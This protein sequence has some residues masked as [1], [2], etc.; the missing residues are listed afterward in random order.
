MSRKKTFVGK[1]LKATNLVLDLTTHKVTLEGLDLQLSTYE[2]SLLKTFMQKPHQVLTRDQLLD[3]MRGLEWETEN[4]SI[5]VAV[6]RLRQKLNDSPKSPQFLK[7]IWGDG[8]CFI[9]NVEEIV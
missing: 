6:S 2:F 7:T 5:D 1:K 9:S 3:E 4:R 8:Y